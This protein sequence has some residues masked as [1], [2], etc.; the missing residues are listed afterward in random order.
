MLI[1]HRGPSNKRAVKIH[2]VSVCIINILV[3]SIFLCDYFIKS[4]YLNIEHL[5][6]SLIQSS[7]DFLRSSNLFM[8]SSNSQIDRKSYC[9]IYL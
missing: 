9:I 8:S 1:L 2:S 7:N 6:I 3:S 5:R 4:V